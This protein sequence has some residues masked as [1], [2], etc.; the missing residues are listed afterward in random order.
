MR[1]VNNFAVEIGKERRDKNTTIW[2]IEN[3]LVIKKKEVVLRKEK[4]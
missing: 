2:I 3:G 4:E 1:I